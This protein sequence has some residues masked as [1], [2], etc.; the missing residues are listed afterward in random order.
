M[1]AGRRRLTARPCC[2]P[3]STAPRRT[4]LP[5]A[6]RH[7]AAAPALRRVP[8]RGRPAPHPPP[9]LM[10]L[11]FLTHRLP[12]AP[13]RG[14]RIRAYHLLH[15]LAAEHEV[16]LVSLVHDADEAAQVDGLRSIARSVTAIPVSRPARLAA[17]ALSLAGD[18]P[19]TQVLLHSPA[20][21]PAL[22]SLI[23]RER[24]EVAVAF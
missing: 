8:G 15:A 22:R 10:R 24:P 23:E 5:G 14:D 16:H 21:R 2:W 17:A 12:Y 13:N 18:R 19:L 6:D 20:I 9:R 11:V 7:A 4:A 3:P 1:A